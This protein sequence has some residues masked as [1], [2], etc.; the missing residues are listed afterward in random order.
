MTATKKKVIIALASLILVMV[1]AVVAVVAVFAARNVTV[2]SGYQI[3]YTALHVKANVSGT[4]Q[5]QNS[6]SPTS[7]SPATLSFTGEEATDGTENVKSFTGVTVTLTAENQYVD[8][9]YTISNGN[10]NAATVALASNPDAGNDNLTYTYTVKVGDAAATPVT[11]NTENFV[12]VN[13]LPI[14]T[15][16]VISVHIAMDSPDAN[17]AANGTFSFILTAINAA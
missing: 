13:N 12:L 2:N 6:V 3:S 7:L 17:V 8:F 11:V 4:Y 5:V 16:A 9:V 14:N 15:D 1:A 10:L